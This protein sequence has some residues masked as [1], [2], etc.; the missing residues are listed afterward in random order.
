MNKIILGII[1]GA[2]IAGAAAALLLN[3]NKGADEPLVSCEGIPNPA[4][5]DQEFKFFL[6]LN[7]KNKNSGNFELDSV[8]VSDNGLA[9]RSNVDRLVLKGAK[10]HPGVLGVIN[11]GKN[12]I[13]ITPVKDVRDKIEQEVLLHVAVKLKDKKRNTTTITSAIC[14]ATIIHARPVVV[15]PPQGQPV[16]KP[17]P[18]ILYKDSS[19]NWV[20][21]Q[22]PQTPQKTTAPTSGLRQTSSFKTHY[23]QY[24]T[25]GEVSW[26]LGVIPLEL[27]D[28]IWGARIMLKGKRYTV[29]AP[30]YSTA[31]INGS[32]WG[33]D[34]N[35]NVM[36]D[37][38][39]VE[40]RWQVDPLLRGRTTSL[41]MNFKQGETSTPPEFLEIEL[42]DKLGARVVGIG[43]PYGGDE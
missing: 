31:N 19:G 8:S 13:A 9:L 34:A 24:H 35:C 5:H 3:L 14:K 7:G 10:P 2:V 16:V 30:Y 25:D 6:D 11:V 32:G 41:G 40:C 37:A 4:P 20:E 28:E 29:Q 27:Y 17:K 18:P 36:G 43:V 12:T 23:K 22:K 21:P 39:S 38:E 15:A 33:A 42:L 1:G 26:G